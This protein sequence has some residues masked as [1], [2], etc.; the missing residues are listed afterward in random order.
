M[1]SQ[2][3]LSLKAKNSLLLISIT[4]F[5]VGSADL[6]DPRGT[7]LAKNGAGSTPVGLVHG[8]APGTSLSSFA[9]APKRV[10]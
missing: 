10:G 4:G 5:L 3:I 6:G 7:A 9:A 2:W 1:F 8:G